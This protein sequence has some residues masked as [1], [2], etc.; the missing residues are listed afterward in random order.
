MQRRRIRRL[1]GATVSSGPS[2]QVSRLQTLVK[3]AQVRGLNDTNPMV[4]GCAVGSERGLRYPSRKI[5]WADMTLIACRDASFA[6]KASIV[7]GQKEPLRSQRRR[8][9]LL[10]S[11]ECLAEGQFPMHL[12]SFSST[13]I[14]RVCSMGRSTMAGP[15]PC[16]PVLR[17]PCMHALQLQRCRANS[18]CEIGSPAR[19]QHTQTVWLADCQSFAG[20][21]RVNRNTKHDVH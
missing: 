17:N 12:I 11:S 5:R 9:C 21:C 16:K 14:R 10:S 8:M 18:I 2:Y 15:M 1:G 3:N 7:H 6:G 19:R 13:V 4:G 20:H